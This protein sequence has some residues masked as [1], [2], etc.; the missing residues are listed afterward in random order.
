MRNPV[1]KVSVSAFYFLGLGCIEFES[2]IS[3]RIVY[4]ICYVCHGSDTS[5]KLINANP[6]I[7]LRIIYV[8]KRLQLIVLMLL[9]IIV[10]LD[11]Q[12][13]LQIV[14]ITREQKRLFILT[15]L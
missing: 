15:P 5:L 10:P 3:S 6:Q 8:K 13:M 1:A 14:D 9:S 12:K 4:S 11:F 7:D 2:G